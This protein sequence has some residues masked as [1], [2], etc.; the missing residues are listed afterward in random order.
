MDVPRIYVTGGRIENFTEG[1]A[2]AIFRPGTKVH[3]WELEQEPFAVM[4]CRPLNA[5]HVGQ[6]YEEG[7]FPR[8]KHC[9]RIREEA[10]NADPQA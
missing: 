6:L 5:A 2:K 3:W 8:C 4:A 9:Q 7:N 10:E 1:W